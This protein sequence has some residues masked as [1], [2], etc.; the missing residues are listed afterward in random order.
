MVFWTPKK[1]G[2][3]SPS[4]VKH[5]RPSGGVL[6]N[7]TEVLHMK[8]ITPQIKGK[9]LYSSVIRDTQSYN[10]T[11]RKVEHVE[12]HSPSAALCKDC[13]E[14]FYLNS[15]GKLQVNGKEYTT[16]PHCEYLKTDE[17]YWV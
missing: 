7:K 3:L 10:A 12:V 11:T 6:Q 17:K 5:K 16:C 13:K 15:A 2:I 1:I 14:V 9:W 4:S 8:T